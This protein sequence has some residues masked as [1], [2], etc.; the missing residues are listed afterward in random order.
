[1]RAPEIPRRAWAT[2]SAIWRGRPDRIAASH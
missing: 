1:M 2:I